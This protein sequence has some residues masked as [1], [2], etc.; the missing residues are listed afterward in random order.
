MYL[1]IVQGRLLPLVP[2]SFQRQKINGLS[3]GTPGINPPVTLCVIYK[4]HVYE[5]GKIFSSR[6]KML[7]AQWYFNG[8]E[9]F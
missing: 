2:E 1:Y 6:E 9:M 5:N 3:P 8:E 7:T 4:R